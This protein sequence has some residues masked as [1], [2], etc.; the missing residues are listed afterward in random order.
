MAFPDK[1]TELALISVAPQGGAAIDMAAVS[2]S[3]DLDIGDK[4]V[5]YTPN[6]KGGRAVKFTPEEV[7]TLTFEGFPVT[8]DT[9]PALAEHLGI[10]QLFFFLR[11]LAFFAS[12]SH[13]QAS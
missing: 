10:L 12:V 8:I 1:W 5:E 13:L 7:S 4:E 9:A 3:I 11:F 6:L 2:D